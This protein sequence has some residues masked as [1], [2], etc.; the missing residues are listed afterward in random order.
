MARA[1]RRSGRTQTEK[2]PD[3]VGATDDDAQT[4]PAQEDNGN[5][6]D[7]GER[8]EDDKCP[9]C[10]NTV[11]PEGEPII[12]ADKE[13]WV[14]CDACKTW[15][16]WRCVGEGGDLDTIG[17]WF[18]RPCLDADPARV[19][20]MKPPARKSARKKMQ[21]D[22][23]GL[24]AGNEADP[25]R[26]LRMME[27]KVIKRDPFAR[28]PGSEVGIEWLEGDESAMKEPILVET[29]EGLGMKMPPA[30]F[31]VDDVVEALGED[32]PVEVI[33]VATQSNT[34]NWT[35]G[36]WL[37]YWNTEPSKRDKIRNVISLEISGTPLADKV[38]PPRIVRELDW[39]EKF[40][41]NTKKGRGHNYPKVQLYCLMG[42]GGAWTDWHVDF[43]GSS[44]YY[45]ILHG[46]KVFYFIRPSHANL[47]AY[48]RW[49]G[50]EVQNHSWLGDMC[51]EV[52]K[53]EL[54]TGNTMIIPTGW[55]HAVYTPVDTLVFGGNFLHSYNVPTQLRVREIEIATHVPK[56]FRFPFFAR[57]CWY[58]GEKYLRDL[59]AKEEFSPRV[60]DSVE[61][62]AE[63]LVAESRTIERGVDPAKR[64]A[65]EEVPGDRIKDAPA[66]AR[67]LRWRVRHAA[68]Y[69][70][71]DDGR[72]HRKA[73]GAVNGDGSTNGTGNKRKRTA[74][75]EDGIELFRNYKRAS[76]DRV[77]DR[78]TERESKLMKARRPNTRSKD[79][80][81]E[82]TG[83]DVKE[84]QEG[85]DEVH[86]ERKRDVIVKV[87]KTAKGL[88]RHRV[89][90]VLENWVWHASPSSA[91][92]SA[93]NSKREPIADAG[94]TAEDPPPAA[95][96]V[97]PTDPD[98]VMHE[99][100]EHAPAPST[101]KEEDGTA[102]VTVSAGS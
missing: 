69:A 95:S 23:A 58:A 87:R 97:G 45:H 44:V 93:P 39:V 98:S 100:Q 80:V 63:F 81:G 3:T 88:E 79:W 99:A 101:A 72:S 47:A 10:K 19:I 35:L 90:R 46:S 71:D 1:R 24:N 5:G 78:P 53:V 77:E 84:D 36:K 14:R 20:T 34:P 85:G 15:F 49:S 50:T 57:L 83:E 66:L 52:F 26:F 33:D 25:S 75:D 29:E 86:V 48:E 89:E 70:S 2:T 60:L 42:V 91:S 76:W 4:Q 55:I 61:A 13:K 11:R 31:T 22:Y 92:S 67:E 32:H 37:E 94:Q 17:K 96:S 16:H 6:E 38:L 65:K 62:L 54:T 40:W 102:L 64:Q 43:A 59:K 8:D 82:W 41:P 68:G 30:G 7:N 27:G 74:L 9:A 12:A 18:C 21:R 51:D 56:K 28:M 73:K